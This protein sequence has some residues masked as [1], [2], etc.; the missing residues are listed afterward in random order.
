M[1]AAIPPSAGVPLRGLAPYAETERDLLGG[2]DRDRD[3]IVKMVTADTFRAGLI[4][5]EPGVGKTSILHAGVIPALRERRVLVMVC[6]DL[7]APAQSFAAEIEA[8][9]AVAPNGDEPALAY[10]A[11][12]VSA[13]PARQQFVF[14]VDDVDLALASDGD[15]VVHELSDL[16]SR[17]I[18]RSAGRARV[19]FTCASERFHLL[20]RLEQ[21]TGSLFPPDSR[22]EL[23]RMD[24][25]DAAAALERI[26]TMGGVPHD[27]DLVDAVVTG[28]GHDG[29]LPADLQLGAIALHEQRLTSA[30][31]LARAGGAGELE[32]AWLTAAC[33]ATG[34]ERN[35]LRIVGE[36]AATGERSAANVAARLG[37][38]VAEV[39][40]SL[41][42]LDERG[43]VMQTDADHGWE[44]R[45]ELL[46]PRIRELT[47]PARAAARRAYDLMG[48][49]AASRQRLTLGE[50]RALRHEGIAPVTPAEQA[51]VQR[52]KRFYM[53]IA[54]AI[55]AVPIVILI[56][57]WASNRG[58]F[59]Y[60][61]T[62]G[63]GGDRVV[64]RAGRAGLSSFHWLPSSPP[65]GSVVVDT[66]L[67][68]SMVDPAAWQRIGS[69]DVG[70]ELA[71]WIDG[72]HGLDT[73][74]RPELAALIRYATSGDE[75]AID[76]LGKLARAPD[77]LAEVL[78]ALRPIARGTKKEVA[79]VD[80]A[81]SMP[82]PSLQKAA[83]AL[84]G[85]AAR[86]GAD[87]YT[88]IL[89]SAMVSGDPEL[90][91]IALTA[92]RGLGDDRA[93]EM[94][95]AALARDPDPGARRELMLEVST[96][97]SDDAPSPDAAV[98]VLSQ[99]DATPVLR[100]RGRDQLRRAFALD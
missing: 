11:R 55:A 66:G 40:R 84:A 33:R 52:S 19:L 18:S 20:G 78:L 31:A 47:A 30:S 10:I 41:V 97:A 43:L 68:R 45:H 62:A 14:V 38:D 83:V 37:L 4:F 90:R 81:L 58:H 16:F 48:S 87:V 92:V 25:T 13:A 24:P 51:V 67:T 73:I 77:D 76:A 6:R 50:L 2:R 49:K 17:V 60:D 27:R 85:E 59:Y 72:G 79:L 74:L 53:A 75:G 88:D 57:L 65:S 82:S 8:Q 89:E 29:V 56:V 99:A 98:S 15:H 93:R 80:Q 34:H 36:L 35:G 12:V 61:L 3:E 54:G 71:G 95:T 70:G 1:A 86:R 26:L 39:T 46:A 69:H 96:A 32:A 64:V 9:V 94:F 63:P 42:V 28:L 22:H 44:L 23:R 21:R 100:Q 91:R 7:G 5:G